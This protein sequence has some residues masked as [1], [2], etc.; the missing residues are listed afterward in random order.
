MLKRQPQAHDPGALASILDLF[1]DRFGPLSRL[2]GYCLPYPEPPWWVYTCDLARV[3]AGAWFRPYP[4]NAAGTS[5]SADVALKR[6]LGE[7][8][9]R[10]CGLYSWQYD[11][12]QR[13]PLSSSPYYTAYPR[14]AAE[15]QGPS[16]F[17]IPDS[18]ILVDHCDAQ[19]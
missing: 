10:Y 6:C 8:A 4:A 12:F 13:L 19:H 5:I 15:E 9:E 7:A 11:H 3:P 16:L 17:R 2:I 18:E 14:C 1:D